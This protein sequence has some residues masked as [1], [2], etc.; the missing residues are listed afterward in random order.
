MDDQVNCDWAKETVRQLK[1][2]KIADTKVLMCEIFN[3]NLIL[4]LKDSIPL[5]SFE[6]ERMLEIISQTFFPPS[7]CKAYHTDYESVAHQGTSTTK[8]DRK[9]VAH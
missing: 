1:K 6:L 3:I 4:T 5:L 2:I 8:E 7:T 9:P